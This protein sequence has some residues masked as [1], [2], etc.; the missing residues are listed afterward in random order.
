M[1]KAN[2]SMNKAQE[3]QRAL[4][5][6]AKRSENRRFH[7]L[8]D[9]VCRTDILWEAW[10]K[11]KA[12]RGAAGID[13]QTIQDIEKSGVEGFLAQLQEELKEGRYRPQAVRRVN[14]P[15]PDGRQRPLGIPVVRDR[16]VQAAV[17]IVIEPIF[18]ADFQGCSYGFRPKRSAHDA[19]ETIR[20]TVNRGYRWVVDA[21]IEN[22]FD[23]IGQ[24][25]LM[26]MV[27][28][29]ISDR[30]VLKLIRK[31]LEAGVLEDGMVRNTSTGTQQGG[32]LSPLLANIYLNHLDKI[33]RGWVTELGVLV[34]YADDLVILCGT[35]AKAQEAL[36]R[37]G[38]VM[39]ELGLRLHPVKTRVVELTEG[40]EGFDFL[41]FH[42]RLVRSWRNG[43]YYLQRWP[44]AKAM[45]AIRE[46]IR[47]IAGALD[48]LKKSLKDVIRELNPI[49]RGWGNYFAKGHSSRHFA[50]LDSYVRERLMLFLSKK[51]GK[52]G[53]GWNQRWKGIDLRQAGLYRLAGTI[54]WSKQTVNAGG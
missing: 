37:L 43:R 49:L 8:Y 26:E 48:R 24:R 22:Y 25:K 6:S 7:A 16:V 2:N 9:Q 42:H 34:R 51:H 33:W 40:R 50:A 32:V 54:R 45:A 35:R 30:R 21:D 1:P 29:R 19:N 28:K 12:N 47:G 5:R 10:E 11:V 3:L 14:I 17:K 20:E 52:S 4:Y 18:E 44:R 13:G 53:R 27:G 23:T 31:F 15:K 46:K 41:G 36:R 39:E 38:M